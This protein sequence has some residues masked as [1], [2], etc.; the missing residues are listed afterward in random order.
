MRYPTILTIAGSDSCGGAGIEAD[1]KTIS[2]LG[3][4]ACCAITAL[5][6]QNTQTV[7]GIEGTSIE[8]MKK[9]IEAVFEDMEVDAVKSGMLYSASNIRAI[10]ECLRKYRPRHYV[11]DPVMIST[12]GKW[13]IEPDGMDVAKEELF[14]LA[15]LL[16]P[17]IPE[18]EELTGIKI[19]STNDMEKAATKILDMG[20]K[21]VLIKGGHMSKNSSM[22]ILFGNNGERTEMRNNLID[23]K[24]THGTGCTLS[25]AIATYLAKGKDMKEAF[26]CAHE[27][28]FKAIEAGQHVD[29]GHGH[30]PV[31]HQWNPQKLETI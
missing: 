1:I 10:G 5:T 25:S 24:N 11:L 22:D 2:A 27:Y 13:L 9:Q 7:Y 19:A 15:T 12:S 17:N 30:G 16:T 20:C 14:G 8:M 23:T 28:L 21:N 18:T 6:A 29:Q 31:N 3:G 26:E 4:Y